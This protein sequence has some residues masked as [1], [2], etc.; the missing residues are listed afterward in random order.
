MSWEGGFVYFVCFKI[1]WFC[2]S[3]VLHG[4]GRSGETDGGRPEPF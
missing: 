4:K 1:G 3:G 2:Y